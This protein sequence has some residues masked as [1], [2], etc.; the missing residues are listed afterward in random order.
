MEG[1]QSRFQDI[2]VTYAPFVTI[3]SI[4]VPMYG[5]DM[6]YLEDGLAREGRDWALLHKMLWDGSSQRDIQRPPSLGR[7]CIDKWWI[8]VFP[9][10][11]GLA[12]LVS[13]EASLLGWQMAAFSLCALMVFPHVWAS[14]VS[15]CVLISSS[16]K[17]TSEIRSES[18]P[19]F[20]VYLIHSLRPYLQRQSYSEVLRVWFSTYGFWGNTIQPKTVSPQNSNLPE[21]QMWPHL[22]RQPLQI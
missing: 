14:W 1:F 6:S 16:Y 11:P 4:S 22:K 12:G 17:D 10:V 18:T 20:H 15:L 2:C 9:L 3:P 8:L 19:M 13:P 7:S 5:I 21:H